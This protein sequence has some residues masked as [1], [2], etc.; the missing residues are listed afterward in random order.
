LNFE[1]IEHEPAAA[2]AIAGR[3]IDVLR[4]FTHNLAT[5][6]EELGLIGP[7][8][9]ARIWTRHVLNSGLVAPLLSPGTLGDVGSGA[10]LPGMVLA[11][12]RPDVECVL[13]EPMERRVAWLN[14]QQRELQL[15]NVRIIRARAQD[16]AGVETFD[17]VTA[18]AGSSLK[19]LIP[20][21]APLVRAG[22]ELVFMKGERV[23]EE[24]EAATSVIRKFHLQQVRVDVLAADDLTEQTRVFRATVERDVA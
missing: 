14:A 19:K 24:I 1:D 23:H 12:L 6:G 11:I 2:M 8:E 9:G 16:I 10:G 7:L 18:R 15:A 17:Q 20:M 21:T 13:I 22:G 3:R 5:H 4:E